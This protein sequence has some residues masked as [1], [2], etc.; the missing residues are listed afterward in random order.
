M[1]TVERRNHTKEELRER[2]IFA[3]GADEAQQC[4]TLMVGIT[5][6]C[7]EELQN[8]NVSKNMDLTKAGIPLKLILFACDDQEHGMRVLKDACKASNIELDDQCGK[9][10]SLG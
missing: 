8:E 5:Q 2:L 6:K 9:D 7:W 1:S 3:V 4:Y 10:F